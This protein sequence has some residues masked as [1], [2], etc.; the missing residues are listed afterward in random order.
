MKI[1]FIPSGYKGIYN[2]FEAHIIT[3]LKRKHEVKSFLCHNGLSALKL[4]IKS[5][6]PDIVFTLVGFQLPLEMVR[7]V[8]KQHI[9]TAVWFTEDPYYMDRTS[10]LSDY[11]DFIFTIDSAAA[12]YYRINKEHPNVYELPLAT[13][14]KVFFPKEVKEKFKS[15]ICMVGY[16]YPERVRC[17]QYLLQNTSYKIQ[18]VG[19]WKGT[20]YRFRQHPNLQFHDSW[21]Q[22]DVVSNYYNGA[23][24]ILNTHRPFNL[25]QNKNRIGI[26]GKGINNRTFD[27]AAC[28][29]FQLIDYKEDINNYFIDEDEI[30]SYKDFNQL[31]DQINFYLKNE[32]DR[33]RIAQKARARVLKDHTFEKRIE[34]MTS[35]MN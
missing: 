27:V 26:V 20:L 33:I 13:A 10:N 8:R 30:V 28:E 4:A 32:E 35:F 12:D 29:V 19:K 31:I 9:K 15:D 7:W 14:P 6:K 24:I 25:Q 5:F 21:V 2:W 3:E 18:V 1:F 17:I 34:Q 23:K 11:F 16:P 22:P